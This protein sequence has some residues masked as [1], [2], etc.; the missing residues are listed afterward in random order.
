VEPGSPAAIV[1]A[2]EAIDD[3]RLAA[4]T[5]G[6]RDAACRFTWDSYAAALETLIGQVT[7]ET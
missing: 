6:A 7:A 2:L 4:L 5:A 1:T 3:E